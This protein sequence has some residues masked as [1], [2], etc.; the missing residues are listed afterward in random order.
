MSIRFRNKIREYRE[1][2]G[3]TLAQLSKITGLSYAT[4]YQMEQKGGLPRESTRI[5]LQNALKCSWSD[6]FYEVRAAA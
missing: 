1:S 3:L 5:K 6:I 2:H 4:L